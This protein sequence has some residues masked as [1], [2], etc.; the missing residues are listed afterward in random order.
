[1]YSEQAASSITVGLRMQHRPIST[2]NIDFYRGLM[3][4]AVC[5]CRTA[6]WFRLR[7]ISRFLEVAHLAPTCWLWLLSCIGIWT[8]TDREMHQEL[9]ESS[10][11]S[12]RRLRNY[13]SRIHIWYVAVIHTHCEIGKSACE[14]GKE[15]SFPILFY[16]S[17]FTLQTMSS[18]ASCPLF[19]PI[20][21]K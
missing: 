4:A 9:N 16:I 21:C 6:C 7:W 11:R 18:I 1:M 15:L 20:Q 12:P 14:I 19:Y 5:V 13:T 3:T 17:N 10:K 8:C 2:Q